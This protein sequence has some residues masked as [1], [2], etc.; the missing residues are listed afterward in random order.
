MHQPV[1]LRRYRFF[2]IG[3]DHYYYDD[4]ANESHIT[5]LARLCYIP[6]NDLIMKLIQANPKKFYVSY[7]ISGTMVNL[8][9]LYAPE[10]IESFRKL[11]A[12]GQVELLAETSAH[13]LAALKSPQ[14]FRQQ[15][16][17]HVKLME[18]TFGQTP[19]TFRNTELIYSDQLGSDIAQL[20][21]KAMLAEGAKHVLGWKSPNFLYCNAIEPRLKVLLKNFVLSD[22]LAFRFGNQSWNEWPLTADKFAQWIEQLPAN[23]E[24]VN[25][26]M[27]YETFGATH[28]E[29][30]GIFDFLKALPQQLLN[31]HIHFA[32][33]SRL[34]GQLQPVSAIHVPNP[35]SW[36]DEER[37]LTAWLGNELQNEAADKLYALAELAAQCTDPV[38]RKDWQ[39]LQAS[40][41]FYYMSTKFFSSG[42]TKAYAN[43]YDTPYDAFI[44]YMNVLSDFAIRL[45][46]SVSE[47][48]HYP[49]I[50]E[51]QKELELKETRIV[52]LEK[53][54][55][56]KG[57]ATSKTKTAT[58]P[59]KSAASKK[60]SSTKK[61]K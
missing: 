7:S 31:R 12:T 56:K 60:E 44:N 42:Q 10:V 26:F 49:E 4:Y 2:D 11:V 27:N 14:T 3:K 52:Q 53:E 37:D 25:L 20:G 28:K 45:Q 23:E 40:D 24:S 21:F 39:F 46:N 8:L 38:L 13:S 17:D 32:T 30:T 48:T 34:A 22:D 57:I 43:P 15:V 50:K 58:A 55:V 6:A 54:L 51:L 33:P 16:S 41:H 9:Q 29:S 61:S 18:E 47:S 35:T 59:K 1:K 19:V 36:A 5:R